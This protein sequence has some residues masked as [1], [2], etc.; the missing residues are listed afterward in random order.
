MSGF[1]RLWAAIAGVLALFLGVVVTQL[2]TGFRPVEVAAAAEAATV[3]VTLSEFAFEPA[4][5]SA[6][7]GVPVTFQIAN[8]GAL[9]HDFTITDVAGTEEI[10]GGASGTLE[11]DALEPGTYEVLCTVPGHADSGMATTLTV[12]EGGATAQV[13]AAEGHGG[14]AASMEGMDPAEMAAKHNQSVEDFP[15]PTE[16]KGNQPLEPRVEADGTKV[17][18]LTADE[19]EW[20]TAP[21]ELQQ[22]LAYNGTVPGPRID[23]NLGDKVRI[24]L[25]NEL[26][27][28]TGLH[29]H[30][31]V[32]PNAMDGVPGLTQPAILPGESFTYE[33]A[34]VN[35]GSHMYHSHFDSANQ[36][37]S[38]LLGAFVVHDPADQPVDADMVMVL[39]DG[40]LGF[41]LNGKSFPATEPLVLK[42]G[43]TARIRYMNE[44]LQ[45]HP[46]HLHGLA[47]RVVAKDGYPLPAPYTGDTINVAPGERIDV[48]VEATDLGAWAWHCHILNHAEAADGMFGMVTAVVV[49]Q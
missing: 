4:A 36:V 49:E 8:T 11:V 15:A 34:A 22:A 38:G 44:G 32:L 47:Q 6:P 24:V 41:T 18:E 5:L 30:G 12:A 26:D 40:P 10:A 27:V 20:E 17:F 19:L 33:F 31:L 39:N 46:M 48:L 1:A 35:A 16:G 42:Q 9:A 3:D 45:I 43:Q 37:P 14:H 29:S 21:G 23:V 7:A 25:S 13:A 2:F 28:P